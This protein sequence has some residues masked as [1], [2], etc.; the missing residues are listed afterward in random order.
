MYEKIDKSLYTPMMRQYL[1][2]KEKNP[3]SILFFRLGDFYEMFFSDALIASKELEIALTGR[4]AGTKEKIPMCGVPHHSSKSYIEKLVKKGFKVAIC[5]Q[6]EDVSVAQGIVKRDVVRVITPGTIIEQDSLNELENNYLICIEETTEFQI[7]YIDLS[8]GET[9]ATTID[10]DYQNL[11]NELISLNTKEIVVSSKFNLDEINNYLKNYDITVSVMDHFEPVSY[12]KDYAEEKYKKVFGRLSN[13]IVKT[14]KRQLLHIQKVKEYDLDTYLKFDIFSSKNLELTETVRTKSRKGSLLWYLDKCCTAMGSRYLKN[15]IEKP[16]INKEVLEFRYDAV[17]EL[18]ENFFVRNEIKE[19]FKSVYDLERIVGRISYG[20]VNA[21]DLLNLKISISKLP[22]LKNILGNLSSLKKYHDQIDTHQTLYQLLEK[23]IVETPSNNLKEGNLIKSGYNAQLDKIKEASINGKEW[24]VKLEKDE[25]QRTGISKL[26]VG[27]NRVF[28]YYIEV[29]KGQIHLVKEN[30][31]YERK[32]TL[33]NSERYIN[34]ELKEMESIILGSEEKSIKLEYQLFLEIREKVSAYISS[35]QLLAKLISEIDMIQSF[36]VVA[37]ENRLVRPTLSEKHAIEIIN[38]RHPVVEKLL[39]S[40]EYVEN[41]IKM[42]L[43]TNMFLITGPN[44]SGKSTY[45]RQLAIIIIM[46]QIGSFVPCTKAEIKIF[47]KI[48]TRIG[49]ADDLINGQSTFMIEMLEVNNALKNAT[50]N[51]LILFDEIGRG[52]ATF[53]GMA[54]AQA[55]IEYIHEEIGCKALFST[56]YHELTQLD[57]H[58]GT[59][60]NVHV[61]AKEKDGKIVFFH[62]VK[63]GSVDKSYGIHVAA[64]AGIPKK[65]LKRGNAILKELEHNAQVHDMNL[66]NYVEPEDEI[67]VE[68]EE[69]PVILELEKIDINTVTPLKALEILNE[70]VNKVKK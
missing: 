49:A 15:S 66:F 44:M 33:S 70:L 22:E 1:D 60:K 48:F 19:I 14:Q 20:N 24:L 2:I 39:E 63:E 28:G 13:Y 57:N 42:D 7:C 61:S 68:I 54:L 62:K 23:S 36:A 10:K 17:T 55:I 9:F 8:T 59:L 3:D 18:I 52:T 29:T 34:P 31:G 32:Q 11:I 16:L 47:D 25:R 21:K 46:A 41:S 5:E 53:D 43:Q 58:L 38:G 27:Y 4:E 30:F 64:L 65:V 51:S 40:S 37:E 56:H 50:R 35:L 67:E 26:K 45:I 6:I 69:N 12:L